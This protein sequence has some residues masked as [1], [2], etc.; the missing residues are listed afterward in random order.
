[1]T[2]LNTEL[3]FEDTK[4]AFLH[5]SNAS[6]KRAYRVYQLVGNEFLSKFGAKLTKIAL[7]IHFPIKPF[8]KPLIFK[9]FCGGETLNEALVNINLLQQMGVTTNLNYGVEIKKSERDFDKTLEKN[10]GAIDF[11]SRKNYINV[12]SCKVSGLRKFFLFKAFFK[13]SSYSC[14]S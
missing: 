13:I 12:I 10:L 14:F 11:A 4:T 8:I 3:S 7:A 5:Y 2:K 1:M 9:Q 6:L